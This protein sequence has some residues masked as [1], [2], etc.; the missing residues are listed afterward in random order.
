V[1]AEALA[2]L[3]P[4]FFYTTRKQKLNKTQQSQDKEAKVVASRTKFS[5]WLDS[6]KGAFDVS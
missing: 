3:D 5:K 2:S 6:N 1:G 4:R